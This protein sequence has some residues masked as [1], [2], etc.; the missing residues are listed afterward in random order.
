[1]PGTDGR[2]TAHQGGQHGRRVDL[3][4]ARR[5]GGLLTGRRASGLVIADGN[6]TQQRDHQLDRDPRRRTRLQAEDLPRLRREIRR[7]IDPGDVDR[8][9][10]ARHPGRI[11]WIPA[12]IPGRRAWNDTGAA[13]AARLAGDRRCCGVQRLAHA[14]Q[15]RSRQLVDALRS[16]GHVITEPV[17]SGRI[18]PRDGRNR[19]GAWPEPEEEGR[20][21]ATLHARSPAV[22]TQGRCDAA[23]APAATTGRAETLTETRQTAPGSPGGATPSVQSRAV[24]A[25]D[26]SSSACARHAGSGRASTLEETL[27]VASG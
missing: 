7:R 11:A 26:D 2:H 4:D 16:Q 20:T 8:K 22:R 12:R 24:A 18:D 23:C 17:E 14:L 15:D 25:P 10:A 9:L 3:D 21:W 1:M 27:L 5:R 6:A 13:R 19:P